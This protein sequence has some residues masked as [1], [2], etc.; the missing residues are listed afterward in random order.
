MRIGK[1]D[2]PSPRS[3]P[4]LPDAITVRGR[5]LC[6]D[7][8]GKVGFTDYFYFLVTG[9][10]PTRNSASSPMPCMVAIAEHGLVPSVQA[11]RMTL[12]AAPEAWQGAMAAGLL[13]MG[14]VVAGSS[15]VAGQATRRSRPGGGAERRLVRR[16][17]Q[18]RACSGWWPRSRRCP[19]SA[20]PSIRPATRAPICSCSSPTSAAYPATMCAML[21]LLEKHAPGDHRAAA[22]DQ[23]QRRD[24]RRDARRRM[25]GRR[26]EGAAAACP[27]GRARRPSLRGERS[28]R[29]ASSC[30]TRPT[31]RSPMTALQPQAGVGAA[32]RRFCRSPGRGDGHLHHRAGGRACISA[33]LGADVIKVER[34]G[35]GDP[36]RAFKGGLYSPHYQTYNRNK[37]S[38]TLDTAKQDDRAVFHE[39]I[40]TPTSSSRISAPAWRRSSAPARRSCSA[41]NPA[42]RLLRDLRLRHERPVRATAPPTTRSRRPRAASCGCS[43]R[44]TSPRVIGPAIADAM[45]GFYAALGVLGALYERQTTGKGR[46][47]DVSMLEAMCHFNLDSFTHFFSEGE[48]MG[49]LSRPQRVAVLRLRMRRRKMA[50]APHV[51]PAEILGGARRR[52]SAGRTCSPIRASPPARRASSTRTTSS[53]FM[54]PIFRTAHARRVVRAPGGRRGAALA[55]LRFERGAGGSAGAAPAARRSRPSTP[56]WERSR[57][58]AAPL[59]FDGERSLDVLPPPTLGEH[60]EEIRRELRERRQHQTRLAGGEGAREAG[61]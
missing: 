40:G 60:S 15:E 24:S 19:A 59:S 30:R 48:I 61:G 42:P 7:L 22:A 32:W 31:R 13:G 1:Q 51:L 11:A 46:R 27:R 4:R 28:G 36:F 43:C 6:R 17:G 14:T 10:M 18:S 58:C 47:V 33:D 29:S 3:P 55:R 16:C 34:P 49:P 25:A 2:S 26:D 41:L 20:I 21:R 23:R 45:T 39:L 44:P 35:T 37:R 53:H 38:I 50:G 9:A 8:I 54:A 52:R 5:D 56:R 57:P 12:A